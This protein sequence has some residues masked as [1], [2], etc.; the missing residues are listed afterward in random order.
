MTLDLVS[1]SGAQIVNVASTPADNYYDPTKW[2]ALPG[3]QVPP[4]PVVGF[5]L[6]PYQNYAT[7]TLSPWI[8]PDVIYP[9]Y[10][11]LQYRGTDGNYHPYCFMARIAQSSHVSSKLLR[12]ADLSSKVYGR[13]LS[14]QGWGGLRVDPRTD[15]FS[16]SAQWFGQVALN[17]LEPGG[18][19]L[20]SVPRLLMS[21]PTF[22]WLHRVPI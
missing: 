21:P 16:E 1:T 17:T 11:S 14:V 20:P 3:D 13:T 5:S 10:V 19:G 12:P 15:R 7:T 6:L 4:N 2:D 9:L 18:L 22:Q 8:V